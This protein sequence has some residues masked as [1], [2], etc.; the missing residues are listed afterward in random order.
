MIYVCMCVYVYVYVYF[1]ICIYEYMLD[2]Y[3][4]VYMYV[5]IYI[6]F[7]VLLCSCCCLS[8]IDSYHF[9]WFISLIFKLY[10][11]CFYFTDLYDLHNH[12]DFTFIHVLYFLFCLCSIISSTCVLSYF[13]IYI[14]C[15][16]IYGPRA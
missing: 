5:C 8:V 7:L 2:I 9:P 13:V 15:S 4:C 12:D 6:Y 1:F 10:L 16:V 3:V 14:C 11:L